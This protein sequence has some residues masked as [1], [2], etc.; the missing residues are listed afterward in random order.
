MNGTYV[1]VVSHGWLAADHPDP[2]GALRKDVKCIQDAHVFWDFLSLYQQPRAAIEEEG[3][4]IALASLHF[5]YGH[6]QWTVWRILT[7]PGDAANPTPYL[8]RGWCVFQTRVGSAGARQVNSLKDGR[9][10]D[11]EKSPVPLAP[12]YFARE[13]R[14]LHFQQD[15]DRQELIELYA[16]VFPRLA[17][18]ESMSASAWT[19]AEVQELLASLPDLWGLREVC[20]LNEAGGGLSPRMERVLREA[21]ESR[22]GALIVEGSAWDRARNG[23]MR[24]LA[25]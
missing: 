7:V 8:R 12:H 13:L 10:M 4:Q 24:R 20:L 18:R 14:R 23:L 9:N 15:V 1:G 5:V 16:R 19:D 17:E 3:F 25:V 6:P 11:H 22:G 2:T 21:M